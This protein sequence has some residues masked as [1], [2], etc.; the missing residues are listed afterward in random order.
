MRV[1]LLVFFLILPKA[2]ADGEQIQFRQVYKPAI[3]NV[4]K[5]DYKLY[6]I[7]PINNAI[8]LTT[9]GS[10]KYVQAMNNG[11]SAET[12]I[13]N[14]ETALEIKNF[15]IAT[16]RVDELFAQI[17]T[18]R[19]PTENELLELADIF[20]QLTDYKPR[21]VAIKAPNISSNHIPFDNKVRQDS[22]NKIA[23]M[24][25]FAGNRNPKLA[26]AFWSK[27]PKAYKENENSVLNRCKGY[28]TRVLREIPFVSAISK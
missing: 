23:T 4:E 16:L 24:T 20:V 15:V 21:F 12:Y 27:I 5:I 17:K 1:I 19:T 26:K 8:T 22:L 6:D 3:H 18:A 11:D 13:A 9:Y 2:F 10:P 7:D 28:L 25:A 14:L